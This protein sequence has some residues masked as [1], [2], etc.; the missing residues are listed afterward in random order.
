MGS[1]MPDGST[2]PKGR[3]IGGCYL[4]QL[5]L[6]PRSFEARAQTLCR[7]HT[8]FR[9]KVSVSTG[10]RMMNEKHKKGDATSTGLT[11]IA[12]QDWKRREVG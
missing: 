9:R 2:G 12:I 5:R 6:P 3:T 4:C 10:P 11:C 1:G 8:P 7:P